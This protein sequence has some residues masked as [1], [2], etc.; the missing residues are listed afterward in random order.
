MVKNSTD[1]FFC[2]TQ[3]NTNAVNTQSVLE[4]THMFVLKEQFTQTF[5]ELHS[6]TAFQHSPTWVKQLEIHFK[7]KMAPYSSTQ[8]S[9][10]NLKRSSLQ[11]FLSL[12]LHRRWTRPTLLYCE[13]PEMFCGLQNK[14]PDFPSTCRWGDDDW[15]YIC[16]W[17]VPLKQQHILADFITSVVLFYS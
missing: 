10:S 12:N 11:R 6:E 2:F 17:T 3:T 15:I 8:R 13:S 7:N 1:V 5:R 16:G 9:Q 14:T 4:V